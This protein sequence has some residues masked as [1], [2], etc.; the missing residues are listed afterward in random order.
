MGQLSIS[1][2]AVS[3][4]AW[5]TLLLVFV[6]GLVA[7]GCG[8]LKPGSNQPEGGAVVEDGPPPVYSAE[9]REEAR[10]RFEAAIAKAEKFDRATATKRL[11]QERFAIDY[12]SLFPNGLEGI[13]LLSVREVKKR[14]E[15]RLDEDADLRY[16]PHRK[17]QAEQQAVV[18]FPHYKVG[19][20]VTIRAVGNRAASGRI[21]YVVKG[22]IQIDGSEFLIRD[23]DVPPQA[24]FDKVKCLKY[25][26][27]FVRKHYDL[28]R[29]D[30]KQSLKPK[31][32][33][34]VYRASGYVNLDDAWRRIDEVIGTDIDP[35]LV[36]LEAEHFA[37]VEEEI[38]RRI[39]DELRA[40]GLIE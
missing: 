22:R 36:Q 34:E 23:I 5:R 29:H 33:K 26:D 3:R 27:L 38:K 10:K 19:D 8:K 7:G 2:A 13:T 4:L 25:R 14:I 21:G 39:E 40:E 18:E 11:L 16:P 24:C 15:E 20:E 9:A 17:E 6:V 1:C 12:D 37:Q 31:I 35:D 32:T 28:P 30:L